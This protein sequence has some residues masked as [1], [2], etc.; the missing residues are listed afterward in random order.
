MTGQYFC[1][2]IRRQI[3]FN[4]FAQIFSFFR[5]AKITRFLKWLGD[6]DIASGALMI[7]N[8]IACEI[9]CCLVE[10]ALWS[11]MEE[12]KNNFI[13]VYPFKALQPRHYEESLRKNKAYMIGGNIVI[14]SYQY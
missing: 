12:A 2:Y 13:D 10:G 14:G 4:S 7:L 6:P 8:Y 5:K 9:I 1:L 3:M 11:R